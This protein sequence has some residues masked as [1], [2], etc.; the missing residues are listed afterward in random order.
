M[1]AIGSEYRLVV[2]RGIMRVGYRE[3]TLGSE[4]QRDFIRQERG[5]AWAKTG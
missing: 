3:G 4:G 5:L 2:E 1:T